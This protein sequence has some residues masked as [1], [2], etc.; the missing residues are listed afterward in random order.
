MSQLMEVDSYVQGDMR[1]YEEETT[2]IMKRAL[3]MRDTHEILFGD[4]C[5]SS[6]EIEDLKDGLK[7]TLLD[8][9]LNLCERNERD[10]RSEITPSFLDILNEAECE[11]AEAQCD[12]ATTYVHY[13]EQEKEFRREYKNL[14]MAGLE[15]EADE[16]L[17][18]EESS[19]LDWICESQGY[20]MS[21]TGYYFHAVAV[22]LWEM[23]LPYTLSG[24]DL[25]NFCPEA[26]DIH[27]NISV[28]V[29]SSQK[30]LFPQMSMS[31]RALFDAD[32]FEAGAN[33]FFPEM[34]TSTRYVIDE[35]ALRL[36]GS[37]I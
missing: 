23:N 36:E 13:H 22:L 24:D 27:P 7:C 26:P 15:A 19:I 1:F 8:I 11:A 34:T 6:E 16:L 35:S 30:V 4:S 21:W 12:L 28:T 14:M 32:S 31:A 2:K 18:Q 25:D 10:G 20:Y 33:D 3:T 37:A 17:E 5:W 9:Y 29:N